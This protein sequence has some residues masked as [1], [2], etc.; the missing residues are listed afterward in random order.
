MLA[1]GENRSSLFLRDN[2]GRTALDWARQIK[3][4]PAIALLRQA[5]LS[6]IEEGRKANTISKDDTH[7]RLRA[8][9]NHQ[10]KELFRSI[11]DS[12][13]EEHAMQ[14]LD[15]NKLFRDEIELI[16]DAKFFADAVDAY[17]F[18]PLICA[19]GMGMVDV[20]DKLLSMDVDIDYTNKFGH[21][22][23]TWACSSGR[24]HT[25]RLL[26]FKGADIYHATVEGKTGLHYACMYAKSSVVEVIINF[27]YEKFATYRQNHPR[28]KF[29]SSRWS[30]Y[31]SIMSNFLEVINFFIH[32]ILCVT[33]I[34][35]SRQKI[36]A[37]NLRRS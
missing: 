27:L 36:R 33:N 14:V 18:T 26:L 30:N 13:N 17:G 7:D 21:T 12:H 24:A 29:D 31:A 9:N 16:P 22:A 8:E 2:K 6:S 11:N 32:F 10:I 19:A 25:A 37:V 1:S 20:V 4:E 34:I 15:N 5:M 23:F 3:S 28:G 35:S